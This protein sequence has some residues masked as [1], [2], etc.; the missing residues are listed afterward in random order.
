M[1]D[2]LTHGRSFHMCDQ[3]MWRLHMEGWIVSA[4]KTY[5]VTSGGQTENMTE[6]HKSYMWNITII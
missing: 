1:N 6:R 2:V 4:T 5:E 3:N